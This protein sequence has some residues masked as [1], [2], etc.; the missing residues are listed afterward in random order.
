MRVDEWD[1]VSMNESCI[2]FT[3]SSTAL[4]I[5]RCPIRRTQRNE[6]EIDRVARAYKLTFPPMS[7]QFVATTIS[8]TVTDNFIRDASFIRASSILIITVVAADEN[9]SIHQYYPSAHTVLYLYFIYVF[10]LYC[11]YFSSSGSLALSDR[12]FECSCRVV[13][14]PK[15]PTLG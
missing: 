13:P 1:R 6:T 5:V 15:V 3:H 11:T 9:G 12:F 10:L 7:R 2:P 8:R 14:V 4:P